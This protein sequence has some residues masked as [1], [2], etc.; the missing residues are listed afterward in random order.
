MTFETRAALF[1]WL[2]QQGLA[3]VARFNLEAVAPVVDPALWKQLR[4]VGA[5]RRLTD[6]ASDDQL[7]RSKEWLSPGPLRDVLP[8]IVATFIESER[9]NAERARGEVAARVAPST[10]LG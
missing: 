3:H 8:G 7:A 4:A 5:R 9:T 2:E 1:A 6:L 10:S